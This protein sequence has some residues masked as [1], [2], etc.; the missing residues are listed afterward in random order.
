MILLKKLRSF[1]Y[2]FRL[3]KNEIDERLARAFH[4]SLAQ[5]DLRYGLLCWGTA[6]NSYLN[7]LKI[8]HRSSSKVLLNR[9]R[10]Y[11][12][13]LLYNVARILDIRHMYYLNLAVVVIRREEKELKKI[14]HKYQT[15]RGC[16]F[17][18]PRTTSSG[19]HK[20]REYIVTKVFNSLPDDPRKI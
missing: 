14:E 6:A 20:S 4:L 2:K 1:L 9:K 15:R 10:R 8:I 3:V 17:L 5:S 19:G 18:V 13:D 16:P 11:A 12:T 7:P